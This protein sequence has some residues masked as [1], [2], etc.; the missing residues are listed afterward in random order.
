MNG[1][2][3]SRNAIAAELGISP[4][5]VTRICQQH[6]PP[7]SFDRLPMVQAAITAAKF[8]AK[9]ARAEIS[10]QTIEQAR[11]LLERFNAPHELTHF[12]K[13]GFIHRAQIDRPTS[14]DVKN[15]AIA[16]GILIDKHA[17]LVKFDTDDADLPAVDAWLVSVMGEPA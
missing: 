4:S 9:A 14:G 12:D 17:A 16:I 6:E 10:Q 7:I 15:Y 3:K 11:E 2:K 8:D 13:D 5:T 1:V